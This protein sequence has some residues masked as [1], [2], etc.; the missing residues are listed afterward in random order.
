MEPTPQSRILMLGN[1][2][3]LAYLLGRYA[4]QSGYEITALPVVPLA[5]DVCA[6]KPAAILFTSVESLEAGQLLIAGLANCE[7]PVLVCSSIADEAHA[8]ELGADQC[9][10][11]PLTY[12]GFYGALTATS[13]AG[14]NGR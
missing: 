8:R 12:D 9:L 7:I 1:D 13:M 3:A 4:H 2:P 5:A 10:V 6:Q 11:H 14:R